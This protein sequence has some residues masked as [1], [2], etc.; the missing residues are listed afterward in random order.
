MNFAV[1]KNTS[2]FWRFAWH[3]AITLMYNAFVVMLYHPPFAAGVD[4]TVIH[5]DPDKFRVTKLF[6]IRLFP[7]IL[8]LL[9]ASCS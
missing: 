7:V 4:L 1:Q 6:I 8:L 9:P 3:A 5:A 2:H